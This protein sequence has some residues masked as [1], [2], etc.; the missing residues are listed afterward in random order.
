MKPI[1]AWVIS[2]QIEQLRT[3]PLDMAVLYRKP[4]E[5]LTDLHVTLSPVGQDKEPEQSIPE[6]CRAESL[7]H[8]EMFAA[9]YLKATGIPPE[10]AILVE[11][12]TEKG[13]EWFFKKKDEPDYK[14]MWKKAK[15]PRRSL[16]GFTSFNHYDNMIEQIEA[17]HTPQATEDE[18]DP[19]PEGK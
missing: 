16:F 3:G 14:A 2:H 19:T 10:E 12:R 4:F 1:K 15:K 13:F 7:R 6:K 8:R 5:G 9:A 18:C 11:Q 17:H